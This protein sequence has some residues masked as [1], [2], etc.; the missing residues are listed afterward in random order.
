MV[1][2]GWVAC[3]K[4][5]GVWFEW[6]LAP[7][8]DPAAPEY[9][10]VCPADGGAH[11]ADRGR[12]AD[13]GFF[14]TRPTAYVNLEGQRAS[15]RRCSKCATLYVPASEDDVDGVGGDCPAPG[16]PHPGRHVEDGQV[17]V[18][19]YV[20]RTGAAPAGRLD[21]SD[22][23]WRRCRS[24]SA[25]FDGRNVSES[26]CPRTDPRGRR[27]EHDPDPTIEYMIGVGRHPLAFI[28]EAELLVIGPAEFEEVANRF[29]DHKSATMQV[30]TTWLSV[31]TAVTFYDALPGDGSGI[32]DPSFVDDPE[33]LKRLIVFAHR[34]LG[35]RYVM[36]CGDASKVPVRY[37]STLIRPD[38]HNWRDQWFVP[39]DNYY[40]NLYLDHEAFDFPLV[41]P[42][43]A[44]E[45]LGSVTHRDALSNWDADGDGRYNAQWWGVN[46][47]NEFAPDRVDGYPDVAVARLP[48]HTA[49]EVDGYITKVINYETAPREGFTPPSV[50]FLL[51]GVLHPDASD[52]TAGI[53]NEAGLA[54]PDSPWQNGANAEPYGR[55]D[56]HF[57]ALS[58]NWP[59]GVAA[60]PELVQ[61]NRPLFVSEA[62][63]TSLWLV[64][65]GHGAVTALDIAET[66]PDGASHSIDNGW[67]SSWTNENLP[68]MF[69]SACLTGQF[70]PAPP[71]GGHYIDLH[72]THHNFQWHTARGADIPG[73]WT[74]GEHAIR[75]LDFG[76]NDP[77][78]TPYGNNAIS[79]AW[80][81]NA[82]NASDAS[83]HPAS[84]AMITPPYPG[85]YDLDRPTASHAA[86]WL[87]AEGGAVAYFGD[88]TV[89]TSVGPAEC[90]AR[91]LKAY[92][93]G[94]SVIGDAYLRGTQQYWLD[95]QSD[96]D[97]I[98]APRIYLSYLHLFGDPSLRLQDA[99]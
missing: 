12:A 2:N 26:H 35:L 16:G 91:I 58:N 8:F 59:P 34:Q 88:I 69:A 51:D 87:F 7:G 70:T 78:A 73:G 65:V 30:S 60:M 99:V 4:C 9:V 67:V 55:T 25:L 93:N 85:P 96:V 53:V 50:T 72:G 94:A 63:N 27:L 41:V 92:R 81:S 66:A 64:Y 54:Q 22:R 29:L 40:A 74:A 10:S 38:D 42:G 80:Q 31:S 46:T 62:A 76:S 95:F 13:C 18:V 56:D 89:T 86:A 24:C 98:T 83:G 37:R 68:V 6:L 21:P 5:Q 44:I 45:V 82:I 71:D 39:A 77:G 23:G 43:E 90:V 49:D 32:N 84:G 28:D 48:A 97:V 33:R 11:E 1:E 52:W 15:W 36:L 19:D 57:L 47:T 61:T 20:E 75:V 79:V 3:S 14:L 17:Y